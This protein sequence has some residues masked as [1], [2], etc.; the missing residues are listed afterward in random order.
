MKDQIKEAIKNSEFFSGINA[1]TLEKLSSIGIIRKFD[2]TEAIFFQ[3]EEALGFYLIMSGSVKIFRTGKDGREQIIHF[4]YAGNV[5]G[6]VPMFQGSGYPAS[7]SCISACSTV[8]FSKKSFYSLAKKDPDVLMNMLA[9]MSMRLRRFVNLVDDLSLK[10][11]TARL[12]RHILEKAGSKKA[13]YIRESKT[14]LAAK[15]GTI[16]A[17]LSRTFKKLEKCGAIKVN[18]SLIEILDKKKLEGILE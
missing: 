17:T 7:A 9:V 16:S 13:F 6:E 12:A 2:P 18:A 8:Y 4:F 10:D 1:G 5:F 15:I 11:V 14:E 3:E